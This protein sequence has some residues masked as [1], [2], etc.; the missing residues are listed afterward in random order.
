MRNNSAVDGAISLR[1]GTEFEHM[2]PELLQGKGQGHTQH[3]RSRGVFFQGGGGMTAYH[4]HK[5]T[6][7]LWCQNA[8]CV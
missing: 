3:D 5:L 1:F 2:T 8:L 4:R 6:S 7:R